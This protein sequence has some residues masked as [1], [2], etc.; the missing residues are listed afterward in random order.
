MST[1]TISLSGSAITG[2][3]GTPTK[4]YTVSDADLQLLLNWATV[5]FANTFA[6]P[7]AP[8]PT[9]QQILIAWI[10]NWV[11]GTKTAV[12]QFLTPASVVPAPIGIA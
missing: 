6:P 1:I 4:S 10:Q 7:P 9:P 3:T 2:L 12:Q 8:P 11:N 5:A